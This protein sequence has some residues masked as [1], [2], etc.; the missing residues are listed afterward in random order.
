[1]EKTL[2]DLVAEASQQIKTY[3]VDEAI[4][5]FNRKSVT[6]IDVRDEPE[7]H[8]DGKIPGAI[9]ASRGMLE[10]YID[11]QSPYHK[12]IFSSDEEKIFYCK[13]GGRSA[14]AAQRA[15]EMGVKN[16][17]HMAGGFNSWKEKGGG[18]EA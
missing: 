16:V 18:V 9:H 8:S 12:D 4:D 13:S 6:F 2:K 5:R 7:L 1:M 17:A 10:F 14:M 3:E 15:Q 11:P